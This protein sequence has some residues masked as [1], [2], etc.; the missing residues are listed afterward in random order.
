[1]ATYGT[2][3]KEWRMRQC[4]MHVMLHHLDST[5]A[6]SWTVA[7]PLVVAYGWVRNASFTASGLGAGIA[8]TTL[9]VQPDCN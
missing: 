7:A 4:K 6:T 2:Q 5:P 8:Y 1:M 3:F 9:N